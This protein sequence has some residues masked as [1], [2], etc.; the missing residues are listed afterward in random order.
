MRRANAVCPGCH[1]DLP[2]PS[3]SVG[4]IEVRCVCGERV[5]VSVDAMRQ[6]TV[7]AGGIP[8]LR[9]RA[10]SRRAIT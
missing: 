9:S 4:L 5:R 10:R 1:R 2:V 7:T 6:A 3:V 8:P